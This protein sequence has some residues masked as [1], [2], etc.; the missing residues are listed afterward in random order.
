MARSRSARRR[1]CRDDRPHRI[2]GRRLR[3]AGDG[4]RSRRD[5]RRAPPRGATLPV[6]VR[7]PAL[8]G[9]GSRIYVFGGLDAN[10]RPS[11]AVQVVDPAGGT[12]RVVGRL[13]RPLDGAAAG[14]LGGTIYLAGGR[15]AAGPTKA[16][17]A[18]QPRGTSFLRAGSLRVA[19]AYAGAAVSDGRLWIVGGESGGGGRSQTSRW[20]SRTRASAEPAIPAPAR[21]SPANSC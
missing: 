1:G 10:G 16:V 5:D 7:Y 13:P 8:A 20:S 11:G 21:R 2:R 19:V 9:L 4:Q 6:P 14:V 12:A 17:Y 15:T 18:F 3:R